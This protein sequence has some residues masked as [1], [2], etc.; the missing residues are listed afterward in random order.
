MC[1]V[2]RS[3][4]CVVSGVRADRRAELE[5]WITCAIAVEA[6]GRYSETSAVFACFARA[7]V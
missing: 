2:V 4:V 5:E 3:Q 7:A 1:M 6:S